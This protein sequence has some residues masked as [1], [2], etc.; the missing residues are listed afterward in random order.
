MRLCSPRTARNC[1]QPGRRHR[2]GIWTASPPPPTD[3]G[4]PKGPGHVLKIELGAL[5]RVRLDGPGSSKGNG[6]PVDPSLTTRAS[7]ESLGLSTFHLVDY[8][9]STE[10]AA[11][12]FAHGEPV[13]SQG[14]CSPTRKARLLRS[15]RR[16]VCGGYASCINRSVS[17]AAEHGVGGPQME[18]LVRIL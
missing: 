7:R 16:V 15:D 10:S 1:H 8:A 5:S 13:S 17:A 9:R 2:L 18:L 12:H 11:A 6:G 4:A 14:G 3:D